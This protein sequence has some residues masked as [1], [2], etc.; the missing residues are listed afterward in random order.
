MPCIVSPLTSMCNK[1]LSSGIF[2]VHLKYSQISPI[3]KNGDETEMS[4]YRL[5]SLLTSFSKVFEK[6]I[7][8]R[9]Q[10]HIQNNNILAKEQ[11]CF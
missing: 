7:Y 11:C 3:F 5:I 9:L 2:P 8:N 1:V 4:D 6:A 10:F